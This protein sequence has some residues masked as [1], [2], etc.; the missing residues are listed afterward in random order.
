MSASALILEKRE[1]PLKAGS[2]SEGYSFFVGNVESVGWR[3][4]DKSAV[5]IFRREPQSGDFIFND[6][7][8][9]VLDSDLP[10]TLNELLRSP[11]VDC[12]PWLLRDRIAP[13][14]TQGWSVDI[15]E[16]AKNP[17]LRLDPKRLCFKFAK[18][19][20]EIEDNEHFKLRDV[21][22]PVPFIKPEI[23]PAQIYRL[24]EIDSVSRGDYDYE[25]C[26]GWELPGR[27]QLLATPQDIFIA[28]IWG[29]AG[30]WF[31]AGSD[32]QNVIV[33]NGCAKVRVKPEARH[34]WPDLVAGLCSEAFRVQMRA[35]ATG[36][37][38]LAEVAES[39]LLDAALPRLKKAEREAMQTAIDKFLTHEGR[40]GKAVG[41]VLSN[42]S[43]WPVPS[44]RKSHSALV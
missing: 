14:G 35:F 10:D 24:V 31:I 5:P 28:L 7:N 41:R 19:R 25:E 9:R 39:D 37:D 34:L 22:D 18:L 11:A 4:G 12:F 33:T 16:V 38:G 36:S 29:S 6:D 20:D 26:Q 17:L 13:T 32:S 44:E 8:E 40:L 30:K 15:A 43:Y 2:D 42:A 27:A 21:I 1:Q 23:N 3:L